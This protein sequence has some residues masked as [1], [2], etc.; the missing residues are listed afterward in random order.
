MAEIFSEIVELEEEGKGD[1]HAAFY[2]I[3]GDV[4][5]PDAVLISY[6]EYIRIL[7]RMQA[8]S[9]FYEENAPQQEVV[10]H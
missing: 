6:Q 10:Y 3:S 5:N 2:S 9:D 1:G 8:L 4:D 7:E